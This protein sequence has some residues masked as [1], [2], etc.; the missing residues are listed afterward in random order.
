MK[1]T[2]LI[3][4]A[5]AGIAVWMLLTSKRA[6]AAQPASPLS[7]AKPSGYTGPTLSQYSAQLVAQGVTGQSL[8]D[9][10]TAYMQTPGVNLGTLSG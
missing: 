5:L 4:I 9:A 6:S 10:V 7:I 8:A 1:E 2:D 3:A